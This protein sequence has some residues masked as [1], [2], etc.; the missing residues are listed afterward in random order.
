MK[1]HRYISLFVFFV[2]LAIGQVI[3]ILGFALAPTYEFAVGCRIFWGLTNCKMMAGPMFLLMNT[4]REYR[5]EFSSKLSLLFLI[6]NYYFLNSTGIFC[7]ILS[8][9]S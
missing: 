1:S 2:Y 7:G 9:I 6:G 8:W 3:A 4:T 5:A